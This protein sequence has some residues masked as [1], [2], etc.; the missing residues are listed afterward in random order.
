MRGFIGIVNH[1][2]DMRY[3]QL[4]LLHH[5]TALTSHKVRFKW[6]E[7]EQ[8]AFDDIN[9]AVSQDTLLEYPDLNER[10]D[11]HMDASNYQLVAVIT[12]HSKTIS[13]YSRKLKGL[14]T[15]DIVTEKELLSIVETLK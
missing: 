10:F 9:R 11:I 4:H 1:Y 2:R 15:R 14:Q 3:K 5:L 8:K 13:F 12:Q 7:L 6:T